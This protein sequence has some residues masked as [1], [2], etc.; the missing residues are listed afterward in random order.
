M[1]ARPCSHQALA[2]P[3]SHPVHA[4]ENAQVGCTLLLVSPHTH[5]LLLA[6]R[7]LLLQT[8]PRAH[9]STPPPSP[10]AS[11]RPG[12]PRGRAGSWVRCPLV[13]PAQRCCRFDPGCHPAESPSVFR[14]CRWWVV[15]PAQLI[16]CIL[17]P[18]P[19][20]STHPHTRGR[21]FH[22]GKKES[23]YWSQFVADERWGADYLQGA[24][25]IKVRSQALR[26]APPLPGAWQTLNPK[27][28]PKVQGF[29][30][31]N[32]IE[33]AAYIYNFLDSS[34]ELACHIR[35]LAGASWTA[36]DGPQTHAR[37]SHCVLFLSSLGPGATQPHTTGLWS[38]PTRHLPRAPPTPCRRSPAGGQPHLQALL[39]P[40]PPP[41]PI[42][43]LEPPDLRPADADLSRPG[44]RCIRSGVQGPEG[45]GWGGGEGGGVPPHAVPSRLQPVLC[46]CASSAAR[47]VAM[48]IG[49]RLPA[50]C[51]CTPAAATSPAGA[52]AACGL[53]ALLRLPRVPCRCSP[54][55]IP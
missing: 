38:L 44:A 3:H 37:M 2:S 43:V 40:G 17:P 11:S 18:P 47:S 34:G 25:I 20:S 22:I 32:L 7:L 14:Q 21:Y 42:R 31:A 35:A 19:P 23:N 12:E 41:R 6:P 53:A 4:V 55:Q 30:V 27:H 5:V 1:V 54:P 50:A 16:R 26:G 10:H 45:A 15:S 49:A 48:A 13:Q 9:S 29:W 52:H 8:W 33:D 24:A 39:P 28:S 36:G 51:P 46:L